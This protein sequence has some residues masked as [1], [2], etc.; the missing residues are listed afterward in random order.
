MYWAVILLCAV[1]TL[2]QDCTRE[3]AV[4]VIQGPAS[5]GN[6]GCLMQGQAFMA[7]FLERRRLPDGELPKVICEWR[8]PK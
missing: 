8:G 5:P 3:T 1:G 2:P 6:V 7:S 4:E